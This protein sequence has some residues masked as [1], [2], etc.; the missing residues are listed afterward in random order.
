MAK[1]LK[2]FLVIFPLCLGMHIVGEKSTCTF[3]KLESTIDKARGTVSPETKASITPMPVDGRI[4]II[5]FINQSSVLLE[6]L[7][8]LF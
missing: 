7:S 3:V 8:V 1:E 4:A 2:S 6:M 5:T